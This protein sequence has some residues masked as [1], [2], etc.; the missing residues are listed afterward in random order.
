MKKYW[1]VFTT[2]LQEAFT[3]RGTQFVWVFGG[4]FWFVV[5]PFVW[6][7]VLKSSGSS[8]I[9]GFDMMAI[10][11]YFFFVPIFEQL[12]D[13]YVVD[14]ME[15]DVKEGK[16][17]KVLLR[18]VSYV[19]YRFANDK[20]WVFSQAILLILVMAV[21]YIAGL[22]RYVDI[23]TPSLFTVLLIPALLM[24]ML[25][26]Y[27]VSFLVGLASFF[28]TRAEW[29]RHLWWMLSGIAAGNL[30]PSSFFP[31]VVEQA[32]RLSP[33]PFMIEIPIRVVMQQIT[34]DD[35]LFRL[36]VGVVWLLVLSGVVWLL[37]RRGIRRVESVGI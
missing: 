10:I 26:R 21:L 32:L 29:A 18:P 17:Y 3:Y 14:S 9:G 13:S 33:F 20:G 8:A 37:W 22:H 2:A 12:T 1:A 6:L 36:L 35:F 28:S 5:L 30:A 11:T 27:I 16:I 23:P 24:G 4:L 34:L 19:L 15:S 25:I 31:P 7:T